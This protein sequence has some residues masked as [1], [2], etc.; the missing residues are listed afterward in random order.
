MDFH[1]ANMDGLQREA[2]TTLNFLYVFI[3]AV[4]SAILK[5]YFESGYEI[6]KI[7]LAVLCLYLTA[8]AVYLVISCMMARD[9]AA[10]TNEPKNLRDREGYTSEQIQNFELENLQLRIDSNRKRNEKTA[11]HL[12]AIR[13]L[14]CFSPLFFL[15][16][17]F[18]GW[19][20]KGLC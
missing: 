4:F 16:A 2:N 19:V 3:S 1:M 20:L 14:L 15:L 6:F 18:G 5:L 11:F 8:T 9:V 10:P 12:N 17:I 7:A 13:F